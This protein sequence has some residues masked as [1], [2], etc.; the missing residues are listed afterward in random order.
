MVA[1]TNG[2]LWRYTIV[3]WQRNYSGALNTTQV[4]SL[5]HK[6]KA[7]FMV[8]VHWHLY[9]HFKTYEYYC[10]FFTWRYYIIMTK[11]WCL[12]IIIIRAFVR[13]LNV[14]WYFGELVYNASHHWKEKHNIMFTNVTVLISFQISS[15]FC[16]R[17]SVDVL[18]SVQ[19]ISC[20]FISSSCFSSM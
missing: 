3:P 16:L 14:L 9:F 11:W 2:G 18:N 6:A 13:S 12:H 17:P 7:T 5:L 15:A 1:W 4:Y 20:A 19:K 10:Q 8:Y